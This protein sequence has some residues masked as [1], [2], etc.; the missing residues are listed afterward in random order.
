[1]ERC[2]KFLFED[3]CHLISDVEKGVGSDVARF[4]DNAKLFM[5]I[6]VREDHEEFQGHLIKEAV[7][8]VEHHMQS[9]VDKYKVMPIAGNNL[10]CSYTLVNSKLTVTV[11]GE[12]KINLG[13]I[14][15]S[16][17]KTSAHCTAE[18]KKSKYYT[19]IPK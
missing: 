11:Q 19:V 8:T 9:I 7:L 12:K 2:L 10:N 17:V 16:S 14:A 13:D 15:S 18:V 4:T 6:S 1:M 3:Y 5:G